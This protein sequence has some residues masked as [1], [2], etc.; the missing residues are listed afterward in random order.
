[1]KKALS[2]VEVIVAI[3]LITI[4]I[5]TMLEMKTNNIFFLEK[6]KNSSLYNSYI[7]MVANKD[8][9]QDNKNI[10]LDK[11][12][13]FDDDEIRKELKEIKIKVKQLDNED[14]PLIKNDY[15]K[16]A[17]IIKRK[18]TIEDKITKV[19]YQFKLEY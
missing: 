2:L 11:E 18:Y 8:K 9:K 15:I 6:F 7:S 17:I 13:D 16:N 1:M 10:Y 4:V 12:V 14:M 3:I 19:F 5:G